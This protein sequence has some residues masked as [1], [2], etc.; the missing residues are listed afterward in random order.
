MF[1]RKRPCCCSR[2]YAMGFAESETFQEQQTQNTAQYCQTALCLS[3]CK[4]VVQ[5]PN[6]PECWSGTLL[7]FLGLFLLSV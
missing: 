7:G 4:V 5:S 2:N 6:E 3:L 1:G